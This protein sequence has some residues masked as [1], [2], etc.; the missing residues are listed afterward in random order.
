MKFGLFPL[1]LLLAPISYAQVCTGSL[2]DPIIKFTF[3]SG[4]NTYG[5]RL[6]SGVTNMTYSETQC[7]E[8]SDVGGYSIV[9]TSGSNCFPGEWLSSVGDHTGDPNGYFML[10]N[11]STPPSDFYLQSVNGLCPSTSYQFAAW[12]INMASHS[13]EILPDITFS[14]EKPDGTV[15]ESFETGNIPVTNPAQWNQYAFYFTTPPGTPSVV[16]RMRNNAPGGYGNDLAIDDITFRTSGPTVSINMTGYAGNTASFCSDPGNAL[17]FTSTVGSCYVSADYQWQVSVDNGISWNNIPGA[18]G[19]TYTDFPTGAGS[20]LYRLTAAQSGNIGISACRVASLPD[21]V[22]V[23]KRPYPAVSIDLTSDHVCADSLATFVSSAVDGGTQPSYQWMVNGLSVGADDP[24]YSNVLADGDQVSCTMIS[25][26]VCAV[27]PVANS[28]TVT[29]HLLPNLATSVGIL[30]SATTIC[31][32]SIV[33]FIALP[34]NGGSDPAYQWMVNGKPV[35]K[36]TA[37]YV[38]G[39]LNNGDIVSAVMTSSLSCTRPAASNTADMTVYDIPRVQLT[40]DT[41]IAGGTYA[42]L[43]PII[44]GDFDNYSWTPSTD[45]ND[46]TL[47]HPTATPASTTIYQVTVS[48]NFGCSTSVKERVEVFY[49]LAMPGAFTPNGDGHNDLFR[50]PPPLNLTIKHFSIY[51]RWG[52]LVFTTTD[53]MRGWDGTIAGQ[54]QP[55]DTYVWVVEYNNP[56]VKR[57]ML[58]KGTVELI[59]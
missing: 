13:G 5:G 16:I 53:S 51:N 56:I 52:V 2:G 22:V 35:G 50:V 9:H 43:H 55:A 3:G 32:D 25:N 27:Q 26:A 59:R 8:G 14:I 21:S 31:H 37:V 40:P 28:N 44:T 46:P 24:A 17:Q 33:E 48:N 38:T 42:I 1:F 15:I 4:T 10:I 19:P 58:K 49:D 23:L 39:N 47:L 20:N 41:I 54:Q 12:V 34:V 6:P 7:P 18:V 11:A 29:M 45:L 57:T 36:D 30:P